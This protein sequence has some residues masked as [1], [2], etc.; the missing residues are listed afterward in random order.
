MVAE[1]YAFSGQWRK[2]KQIFI[3]NGGS[4]VDSKEV[5]VK[6]QGVWR[7]VFSKSFQFTDNISGFNYNVFN[8]V[9]A[10]GQW[11]GLTPVVANITVVGNLGSSTASTINWQAYLD[12]YPDVVSAGAGWAR[13]LISYAQWHY[14]HGGQA[15]GRILD[16]NLALPSFDTGLLPLGSVVNLFVNSGTGIIGSGGAGG[17]GGLYDDSHAAVDAPTPGSI[18]GVA[19]KAR[20][21][22]TIYNNG[23]IGGGGGGGGG[24]AGAG[25][26]Q[27]FDDPGT[28]GGGGAG[29]TQGPGGGSFR[30]GSFLGQPGSIGHGG[31]AG[32]LSNQGSKEWAQATAGGAGGDEGQPGL[33]STAS[34][35]GPGLNGGPAGSAVEGAS[36]VTWQ[37]YGDVRGP[38][39]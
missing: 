20:V 21:A 5:W 9:T 31:A 1:T 27:G 17:Y 24:G 8:S 15:E 4:W 25:P 18:G 26:S 29:I 34:A 35:G 33:A 32:T 2:A 11:D 13:G 36:F 12:R 39:A 28:G 14:S 3:H 37:V 23:I 10:T 30:S 38:L 7:L 16:Y 22:T 6:D 19:V